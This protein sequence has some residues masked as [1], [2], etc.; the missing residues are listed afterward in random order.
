MLLQ[1]KARN[2]HPVLPLSANAKI[3]LIGPMADT[4]DMQGAWGGGKEADTI[5]VR[6][7]LEEWASA[8]G[9]SVVYARGTDIAS[10]SDAG[11][12]VAEA[13]A[14]EADIVVLA[15]GASSGF[16]GEAASRAHLALPGNQQQ[17]LDRIAS[18]GKPVVLLL[19]SG[20][21]LV[22]TPA[23]KE[24]DSIL[25][26]W[27]PATEAGQAIARVLY[28]KVSPG[29][30]LPVSFPETEGQE[31]LYYN[32]LPTGRYRFSI[33]PG[34]SRL[35]RACTTSCT[36]YGS[37]AT[38]SLQAMLHFGWFDDTTEL[39]SPFT[40]SGRRLRPAPYP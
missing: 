18:L 3:A 32:Q 9:G 16:S 19:F 29:G 8:H 38:L 25:E 37:A 15:L 27:F 35:S 6:A 12:A 17:L 30:K 10:S 24:V 13:A 31:P 23:V 7:G 21:P 2:G 36:T 26:V 33:M 5:A 34:I 22:L 20:R 1:N 39:V 40:P 14:R 4:R 28:G 11:F